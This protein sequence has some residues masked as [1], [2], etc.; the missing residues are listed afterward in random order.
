M[1]RLLHQSIAFFA[2]VRPPL[3][4]SLI[5]IIEY[6]VATVLSLVVDALASSLATGGQS[7]EIFLVGDL[8]CGQERTLSTHKKPRTGRGFS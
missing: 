2:S 7:A 4:F 8:S 1:L 6:R 3:L 5:L